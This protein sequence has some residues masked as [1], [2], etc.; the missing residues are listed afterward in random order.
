MFLGRF[1]GKN[2]NLFYTVSSMQK[3][4]KFLRFSMSSIK[5]FFV[6]VF[7]LLVSDICAVGLSVFLL[8][9]SFF[10]QTG[11]ILLSDLLFVEGAII[12]S[13]GSFLYFFFSMG[14]SGEVKETH[15]RYMK[16]GVLMVVIGVIL[17]L[18]CIS[19]GE[20]FL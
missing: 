3:I 10:D 2:T 1:K 13:V 20:L 16:L 9:G 17:V 12:F 6:I 19:I 4:K 7:L 5:K 11:I 14:Y 8:H 15:K 18:A